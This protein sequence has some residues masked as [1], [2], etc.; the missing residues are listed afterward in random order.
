MEAPNTSPVHL[1]PSGAGPR[2]GVVS[3]GPGTRRDG[4]APSPPDGPRETRRAA[5]AGGPGRTAG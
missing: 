4:L 1:G 3:D 2:G 5:G